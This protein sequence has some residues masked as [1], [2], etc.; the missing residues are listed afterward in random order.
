MATP[1][2]PFTLAWLIGLWIA[3]WVALPVI[4]LGIAA[5]VAIVGMILAWHLPKP[6]WI[7]VL[8]LAAMLGALCYNLAQPHFDPRR[9]TGLRL[10]YN[11]SRHEAT[12]CVHDW[13]SGRL[14]SL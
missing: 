4:A 8:A 7:F 3:S 1:L 6:R 5:G 14:A 12:H 10:C 13:C 2:I 11:T 9:D